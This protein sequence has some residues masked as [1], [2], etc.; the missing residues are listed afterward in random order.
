MWKRGH[1]SRFCFVLKS[2]VYLSMFIKKKKKKTIKALWYSLCHLVLGKH[3][4][5]IV[6]MCGCQ[7]NATLPIMTSQWVFTVTSLHHCYAPHFMNWANISSLGKQHFVHCKFEQ[8]YRLVIFISGYSLFLKYILCKPIF[9][10]LQIS[11]SSIRIE[12]RIHQLNENVDW[13]SGFEMCSI[14]CGDFKVTFLIYVG[15]IVISAIS[16]YVKFNI[17]Q[18]GTTN[19]YERSH[20]KPNYAIYK[21]NACHCHSYTWN[22]IKILMQTTVLFCQT[23]IFELKFTKFCI[24]PYYPPG[25]NMALVCN[26]ST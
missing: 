18:N 14:L 6:C 4:L 23:L 19:K 26:C 11:A 3:H 1:P 22:T 7:D 16:V 8:N 25:V 15:Q 10:S 2:Q 17:F 21:S 24:V 9:L 5:P 20:F 13:T 12:T